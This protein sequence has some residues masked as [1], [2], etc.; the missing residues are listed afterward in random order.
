ME[1]KTLL[2][3]IIF[4]TLNFIAKDEFCFWKTAQNKEP[5]NYNKFCIGIF[6]I[7]LIF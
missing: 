3:Y 7:I 6:S 1:N 4:L 5:L 2:I